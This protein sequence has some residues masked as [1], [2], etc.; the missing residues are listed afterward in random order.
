MA[1]GCSS[2]T[3][4]AISVGGFTGL[5]R[6]APARR[7][8]GATGERASVNLALLPLMFN[9]L[10]GDGSGR[11]ELGIGPLFSL[12]GGNATDVEGT[13]ID[14]YGVGLAGVTSTIGYRYHPP[15][16]CLIFRGGL[17]PFYSGGPQVW[18]GLSLGYAF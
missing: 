1:G 18:V 11:L 2:E 12:A 9:W 3:L 14:F 16:G 13:D 6:N 5:R 10:L 4:P 17:V 7:C 15:D 8:V